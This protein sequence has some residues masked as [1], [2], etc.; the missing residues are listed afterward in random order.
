MA[1]HIQVQTRGKS[2]IEDKGALGRTVVNKKPIGENWGL[3]V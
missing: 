2:F 1:N 3:E